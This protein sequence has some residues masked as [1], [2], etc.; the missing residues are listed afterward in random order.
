M[1][2]LMEKGEIIGRVN[3]V[4]LTGDTYEALS[5]IVA[6]GE[7]AEWVGGSLFTPPIQIARLRRLHDEL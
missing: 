3:D 4:M 6:M 5:N 2:D 7:S 1:R